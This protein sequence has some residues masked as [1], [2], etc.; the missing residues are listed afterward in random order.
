MKNSGAYISKNIKKGILHRAA[1]FSLCAML[2]IGSVFTLAACKNS[3]DTWQPAGMKLASSEDADYKLWIPES[4]T[5]DMSTGITS[6]YVS[7]ADLSNISLV[8]MNLS[9]DDNYLTPEDYWESYKADLAATFPDIAYDEDTA[10][11]ISLLL[12]GTAAMKYSYTATVTGTAFHFQS[13]ICIKNG[14][15]Y[16]L[17]YTAQPASYE[18]NLE[19]VQSIIDNFKFSN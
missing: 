10:N 17:T 9:G 5:V 19:S 7:S 1:A 15:V 16:L 2:M 14:T 12:D 4:W 13:V 6:A 8:A 11:G 18:R 3:E